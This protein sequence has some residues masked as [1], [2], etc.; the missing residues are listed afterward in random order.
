MILTN[1]TVIVDCFK[2][3]QSNK[4]KNLKLKKQ[5]KAKQNKQTKKNYVVWKF[6]PICVK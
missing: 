6:W 3:H 1:I 5:N 4:W 2:P